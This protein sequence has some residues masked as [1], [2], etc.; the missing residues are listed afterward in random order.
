MPYRKKTTKKKR[1]SPARRMRITKSPTPTTMTT[2]MRYSTRI[3]LSPTVLAAVHVF[4]ANDL[5]DP[6]FTGVGHQPRGFDQL[7]Q[8]YDHF[9]VLYSKI[10]VKFA[11]GDGNLSQHVGI[12]LRD[13]SPAE[14]NDIDYIEQ[15]TV[16]SRVLGRS[17]STPT[18]MLSLSC[19]PSKFL[20]Q[21]A[22][23]SNMR[24]TVTT[25]PVELAFYHVFAQGLATASDP[26]VVDCILTIDYLVQLTEPK[27]LTMS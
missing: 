18:G 22:T 9:R 3:Q 6:D 4:R 10:N 27:D 25:T 23:N 12:A 17:D 13:D 15:G 24:G 5:Y 8:L 7:M 2:K 21:P 20:G 16:R 14:A 26:G 1:R 11:N 19:T